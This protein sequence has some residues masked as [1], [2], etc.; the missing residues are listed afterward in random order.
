M[1]NRILQI[2]FLCVVALLLSTGVAWSHPLSSRM[3]IAEHTPDHNATPA[4]E[5]TQPR[6]QTAPPSQPTNTPQVNTPDA[7][8]L[9]RQGESATPQALQ[10]NPSVPY[11]PY[12]INAMREMNRGIYG[13]K[14][15]KS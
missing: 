4:I 2:L 6:A 8:S 15:G 5:T 1:L 14:P 13:E 7:T 10:A 9:D 12:D 3:L 11:D